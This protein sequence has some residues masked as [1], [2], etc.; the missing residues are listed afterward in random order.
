MWQGGEGS[1]PAGL[2][3][4]AKVPRNADFITME[5]TLNDAETH[6]PFRVDYFDSILAWP[7]DMLSDKRLALGSR[8]FPTLIGISIMRLARPEPMAMGCLQQCLL[9]GLICSLQPVYY[10]CTKLHSM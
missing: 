6:V 2:C 7:R 9:W 5:F 1:T 4:D 3:F 10:P 8:A